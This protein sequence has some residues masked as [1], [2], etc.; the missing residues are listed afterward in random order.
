[1]ARKAF[2]VPLAVAIAA[3]VP[4]RGL[5]SPTINRTTT[6]IHKQESSSHAKTLVPR[7][8]PEKVFEYEQPLMLSRSPARALFAQHNDH[9]SHRSHYSHYSHA[10][11]SSAQ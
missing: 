3:L 1:M 11:H 4:D 5:P 10:S 8:E 2:L 7:L 9:A 6:G